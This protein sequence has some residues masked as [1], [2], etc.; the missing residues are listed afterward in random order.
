[1]PQQDTADSRASG[2]TTVKPIQ[3]RGRFL[4]AVALRPE[5]APDAAFYQA[6]DEQLRLAPQF[7]VG[8]PLIIDL[9][10]AAELS[11]AQEFGA[12]V[13]N[14]KS[15]KLS[16]FGVQNASAAQKDAAAK[17]GLISVP[18]G[19]DAPLRAVTPDRPKPAEA[20]EKPRKPTTLIVTKPVRSGQSVVADQGDL[21]VVG[22][23]ASGAE[24]VAAGNIHV[25]GPLRGRALAG[26]RGDESARIFCQS[27]DA[28]LLAVAGLYRTSETLEPSVRKRSVHI[29]LQDERLCVEVL[30]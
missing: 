17:A 6:L 26:V 18:A 2:L 28:E 29:F 11:D 10:R 22:P 25:Y 24:L 9:D 14:L 23:V 5:G 19:H 7:L 30:A 15:R 1:M 12:L 16:A 8:A 13:E 27:L 20:V 21:I 4:T 3:I